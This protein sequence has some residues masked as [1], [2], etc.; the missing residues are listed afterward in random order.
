[1]PAPAGPRTFDPQKP[2]LGQL[3][4]LL[5]DYRC[6]KYDAEVADILGQ[7]RNW[8]EQRAGQVSRPAIVLDIDETSLSNW[9]QIYRNDFG[10]IAGGSCDVDQQ[11][12]CGQRDWELSANAE[13]IQPT[14]DLFNAAK[15]QNVA[16]FF[17][18]GRR[19]DPVERAAT[20][21]NLLKVGY[22]GWDGLRLR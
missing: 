1:C 7:A 15:R 5:R 10:F 18:T 21:Q 6:A 8:L 12:A 16:V 11:S 22:H 4:L 13:A 9:P 20:E 17:I 3:K 2:N 19:D 14:L